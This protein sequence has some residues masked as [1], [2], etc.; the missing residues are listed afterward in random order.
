MR[1]IVAKISP[2]KTT[3]ATYVF[4][5]SLLALSGVKAAL[6]IA[7][8]FAAA[9]LT[10]LVASATAYKLDAFPPQALVLVVAATL[11]ALGWVGARVGFAGPA[12]IRAQ[13]LSIAVSWQGDGSQCRALAAGRGT[14]DNTRNSSR[15]FALSGLA[16]AFHDLVAGQ[17]QRRGIH[18][19]VH[20]FAQVAALSLAAR[21]AGTT[22][23][24]ADGAVYICP[25]PVANRKLMLEPLHD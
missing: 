19:D 25:D 11:P 22:V 12:S 21:A 7:W 6:V 10:G 1:A 17:R 14:A 20:G 23:D 4:V 13:R 2:F 16:A 3:R 18:P 9:V 8:A 24:P 5:L 15:A